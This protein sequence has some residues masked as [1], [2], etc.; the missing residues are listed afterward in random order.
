MRFEIEVELE[1]QVY[2][3]AIALE[4]P[5]FFRELR[6][7]EER[8]EAG[9]KA[10]FTREAAQV[11]LEMGGNNTLANIVSGLVGDFPI[12]QQLLALPIIQEQQGPDPVAIFRKWLAHILILRPLPSLIQGDSEEETLEPNLAVT[13]LGA[14]FSGL[15][16]YAPSA[17][18]EMDNFL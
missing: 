6:V 16:A 2:R 1:T 3:Y 14:W 8:L 11:H 13:N 17:Y 7:L 9:G 12:D 18:A 4:L 10:I 15:L 5:K